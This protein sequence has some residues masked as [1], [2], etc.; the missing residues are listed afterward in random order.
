M[1]PRRIL[2]FSLLYSPFWGGAELAVKE[3]TDRIPTADIH[4]D[5]VTLRADAALPVTQRV[6]NI[7][8]HRIGPAR[9]DM[10]HGDLMRFPWYLIKVLFPVLAAWKAR[11][12]AKEHRYDAL[13]CL[14]TYMGFPAVLSRMLGVRA[15]FL[16]TLQDGDTPEHIAQRW[17]IKL[18][19]PLFKKIFRDASA[20]QAISTYLGAFARHMGYRGTPVII[21]NGVDLARYTRTN[22]Q[23]VAKIKETFHK[24]DTELLVVTTSRLVPKNGVGDVIAALPKLPFV[25]FFVLGDGYLR[26]SLE[27]QARALGVSERVVFFGS[28][29]QEQIPDYLHA[30]DIFIRPSL[31]EGLGSSF[32]EAMAAGLPVVAT[33]VGGI[34]DFLFDVEEYG[35]DATGV[36]CCPRNP[37]SIVFALTRLAQDVGLR[38]RIA[39][40]GKKL[41]VERYDWDDIARNMRHILET[42]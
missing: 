4:F 15:P 38:Q 30:C 5:M 24:K 22:E 10:T 26:A 11:A 37:E 40:N 25:R 32:L 28:V 16:L 3:I 8:V 19:S 33:P 27:E 29:P 35:D 36:F 42:L 31:S 23:A 39:A 34:P 13:W 21:P 12:L 2:V 9:R 1:H 41:A 17:R 14:M 18:F 7:T 6:G 20:V